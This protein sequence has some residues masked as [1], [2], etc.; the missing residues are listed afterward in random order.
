M[1]TKN[2]KEFAPK[3]LKLFLNLKKNWAMC[4]NICFINRPLCDVFFLTF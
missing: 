1:L 4:S 2:K 3:I